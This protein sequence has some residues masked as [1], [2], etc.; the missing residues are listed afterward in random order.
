M[1]QN[2]KR[3]GKR[4]PRI[5]I[6]YVISPFN[7]HCLVET[8]NEFKDLGIDGFKFIHLNYI[9]ED[10]AKIFNIHFLDICKVSPSSL[11]RISPKNMDEFILADQIKM[12][13]K[14]YPASF[15]SIN[16]ESPKDIRIYYKNPEVFIGRK[17]CF[18]AWLHAQILSN[19]DV[20]PEARCF[21]PRLGNIYEQDFSQIWNNLN[22]RRL[23]KRIKSIGVT[24]ACS[25]CFGLLR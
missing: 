19:G 1:G 10:M 17:R 21:H 11:S 18:N 20:I 22:Y 8:I 16:L 6:N 25:R 13:K 9:T 2:K 14:E 7:A 4:Q 24:P 5:Y 15:F 12:V 3:L 23:R